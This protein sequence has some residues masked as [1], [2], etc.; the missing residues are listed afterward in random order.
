M[1]KILDVMQNFEANIRG[2]DLAVDE[3]HEPNHKAL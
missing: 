1:E 3:D 2:V